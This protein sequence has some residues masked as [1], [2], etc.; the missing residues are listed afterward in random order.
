MIKSTRSLRLI[1]LAT[2]AILGITTAPA[3]AGVILSPVTALASATDG[4][5]IARTIDQ[6]G[7]SAGFTSGSTDFDA[8]IA[9]NPTHATPDASNAWTAA[10]GNLPINLDFGLGG[11]YSIGDL[12]LWTSFQGFSINRFTVFTAMDASFSGGINV[13]SFDAN[14]TNP[15][16]A[17]VFGLAPSVGSFLRVQIQSNEGAGFVNLSEIAVEVAPAT[18]PEPASLLLLG[19]GLAGAVARARRREKKQLS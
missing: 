13:G 9:S 2:V 12:A 15:V 6:S 18:V 16:I 11:T 5:D 14:D 7:L 8:Y 1:I 17:Q 10:I 3:S 19:T 4:G